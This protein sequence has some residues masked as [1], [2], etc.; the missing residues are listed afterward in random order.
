[1]KLPCLLRIL[2]P[3]TRRQTLA[4]L[5]LGVLLALAGCTTPIGADRLPPR[6]AYREITESALDTGRLSSHSQLVLHRYNLDVAFR[7]AP[8]AALLSLHRQATNDPRRDVLFALAELNYQHAHQLRRSVKPGAPARAPDHFLAAAIYAYLFLLDPQ[9][10]LAPPPGPYDRRFRQ[11]GDLYNRGLAWGMRTDPAHGEYLQLTT[12]IRSLAPGPVALTLERANFKWDFAELE[13]FLPADD[14]SV[15][16]LSVRDRQGGLGAPLV[17]AGKRLEPKRPARRFPRHAVHAG[18]RRCRLVERGRPDRF[19]GIDF[20][21][22]ARLGGGGGPAGAA[23]TRP[24]RAA[25]LGVE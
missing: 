8:E 4:I 10:G 19:V 11:A 15:R 18:Q 5:S 7:R 2:S 17:V 3:W 25:G 13:A 22:S 1:M 16:G 14:Y 20:Q 21:L 9:P 23:G 12:G 6:T 24:D